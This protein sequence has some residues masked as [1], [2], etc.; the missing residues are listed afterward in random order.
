MAPYHDY[1]GAND[2]WV[3]PRRSNYEEIYDEYEALPVH[4]PHRHHREYAQNSPFFQGKPLAEQLAE[5][6]AESDDEKEAVQ[7]ESEDDL[8]HAMIT[9]MSDMGLLESVEDQMR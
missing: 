9:A 1:Y 7:V 3:N 4:T 6:L 2:E 5:Q 8:A